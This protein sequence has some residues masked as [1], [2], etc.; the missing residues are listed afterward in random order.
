VIVVDA[1]IACKWLFLEADSDRAITLLERH[2]GRLIAPDL[3]LSEVTGA[4]VRQHNTGLSSAE[5]SDAKLREWS[6]ILETTAMTLV[7]TSD[8]LMQ[9]A[10]M[11]AME[12]KHPLSDCVYL[13]LA[14]AHDWELATSDAKFAA[15]SKRL[16]ARVLLLDQFHL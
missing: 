10:A 16:S 2:A 8:A 6:A 4:V 9:Q 11:I 3:L 7:R 13:A 14:D 15:R 12:L 5:D 1:S